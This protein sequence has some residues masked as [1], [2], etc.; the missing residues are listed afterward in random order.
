[1]YVTKAM[2]LF[3]IRNNMKITLIIFRCFFMGVRLSKTKVSTHFTILKGTQIRIVDDFKI[4]NIARV[5]T[6]GKFVLKSKII[7]NRILLY[8]ASQTS[9][10]INFE[11]INQQISG[12]NAFVTNGILF[13]NNST[14]LS[15]TLQIDNNATFTKGIVHNRDFISPIGGVHFHLNDTLRVTPVFLLK[16]T[17]T[18]PLTIALSLNLMIELQQ[19]FPIDKKPPL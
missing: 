17:S 12:T 6:D 13:Q 4:M 8:T 11:G 16:N 2:S 7:N 19:G 3:S 1:M 18:S 9:S 10:K 15:G 14:A 5:V